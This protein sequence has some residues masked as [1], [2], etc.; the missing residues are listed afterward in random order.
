MKLDLRS[1]A[2]LRICFAAILL[3]DLGVR[4]TDL[5]AHY[6]DW[7]VVTREALLQRNWHPAFWSLHM[8][9][10]SWGWMLCL[11]ALTAC[12]YAA[13]LVGYR[14]RLAGILSWALLISMQTRAPVVLDGGDLYFR[15]LLFWLMFS[16]WGVCWSADNGW[17]TVRGEAWGMAEFAYTAQLAMIYVFAFL[18]KTAP[19]W[20]A[21]GT[22]VEYA[23]QIEQL[24]RPSAAWLLSHPEWLRP[25]TWS[26]IYFEGVVPLLLWHR[27]T[28]W[29]AVVGLTALHAG[30][31]LFMH[32]GCFGWI[33][34]TSSWGLLPGGFWNLLGKTRWGSRL[35]VSSPEQAVPES[36]QSPWLAAILAF[37][38]FRCAQY[39]VVD[40]HGRYV[41]LFPYDLYAL[42][43]DQ[44][45]NMFS[46]KPLLEDGWYVFVGE[47]ANGEQVDPWHDRSDVIWSKPLQVADE[48]PNARWR[49]LMM[50]LWD[51]NQSAWRAPVLSYLVRRWDELHPQQPLRF[52][53]MYFVLET[54]LPGQKTAPLEA[55]SVASYA[56]ERWL[57]GGEA[58][59]FPALESGL[60]VLQALRTATSGK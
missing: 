37:L 17:R 5:Q 31:G 29:L 53:Q 56:P 13:L 11:F 26:V 41:V 34:L 6:T 25:L 58:E 52:V 18:Y 60:Q 44:K 9:G 10:G 50:N 32:L 22:A 1:L 12:C 57:Q 28:R 55:R 3:L 21:Q 27:R 49:K 40:W 38:L 35:A 16:R 2:L 48:Y 7:G 42:R 59:A 19:E 39:N 47:T 30:F 43:L 4:A 33:A 45:W 15:C 8:L 20:H 23:L 36:K 46:P 54:T 14:T 51:R 24:T